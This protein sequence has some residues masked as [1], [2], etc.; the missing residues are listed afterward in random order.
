LTPLA[1]VNAA[2][3]TELT[4]AHAKLADADKLANENAQ[5]IADLTAKTEKVE[6]L[7]AIKAAERLAAQG[8]PQPVSLVG[9]NASSVSHLETFNALKGAEATA[10]FNKFKTEIA[11]EQRAL[12]KTKS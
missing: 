5:T 6:E 11:A 2:L 1:E 8:H 9:D 3:Q 12:S 7:A 4:E 10:Y